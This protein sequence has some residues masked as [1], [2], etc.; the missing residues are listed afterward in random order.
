MKQLLIIIG[1]LAYPLYAQQ[2]IAQDSTGLI[3][4]VKEKYGGL[5][6]DTCSVVMLHN[7]QFVL[8]KKE[9]STGWFPASFHSVRI[10]ERLA[11]NTRQ[12]V[13]ADELKKSDADVDLRNIN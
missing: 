11:V 5:I 8:V 6:I 1:L 9:G 3:V 2:V 13:A 4:E 7:N 10:V 12:L